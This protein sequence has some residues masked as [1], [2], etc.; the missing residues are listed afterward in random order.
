MTTIVD[1]LEVEEL[2]NMRNVTLSFFEEMQQRFSNGFWLGI[3]I[4]LSVGT[5]AAVLV[6][7]FHKRLR[8]IL[9]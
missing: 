1:K 3:L 8:Y 6:Q 7:I 2:Q 4:G 5:G 9:I